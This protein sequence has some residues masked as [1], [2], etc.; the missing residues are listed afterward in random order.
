MRLPKLRRQKPRNRAFVR[1][2]G[3]KIYLGRRDVLQNEANY[4]AFINEI[5]APVPQLP[6]DTPPTIA[7]LALAFLT[8]RKNYYVKVRR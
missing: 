6:K 4:R 3:K 1:H 2:D 8:A 7:D 5:T